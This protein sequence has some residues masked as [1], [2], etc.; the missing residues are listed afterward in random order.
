MLSI[1]SLS[2]ASGAANYFAK[3][4]EGHAANYYAEDQLQSKW[5][6]GAKEALGLGDGHVDEKTLERILDGRISKTQTLGRV[7][8]GVRFRD[9]GR[10][11][12]FSAP[13]SV[14][15]AATGDM[16][17]PI[18]EA[19]TKAVDTAMAYYEKKFAQRRVWD[20]AQG[21]Q[22]RQADQ[23]IVYA[24]FLDY[25]SRANDPQI[26]VHNAVANITEGPDGK[27][28]SQDFALG[29]R[30]KILLGAIFRAEL[31]KDMQK[32]G[33]QIKPAGKNGLWELAGSQDEILRTF[34]KRREAMERQAPHKISDPKAMAKLAQT[35]RPAK[36]K[37][38]KTDLLERWNKEMA[39]LGETRESFVQALKSAKTPEV[40]E[41]TAKTAIDFALDYH[42]ENDRHFDKYKFLKTA[43][44]RVYGHVDIKSMEAELETRLSKDQMRVSEGGRWLIPT[45]TL[46]TEKAILSEM[47]KG[48]LQGRVLTGKEFREITNLD[49]LTPGQQRAA[50][51]LL[52]DH[53]RFV[54]INGTAGTGKTFMLEQTL[55]HLKSKGYEL[56]G[57]APSHKALSGLKDT[58]VFD[59][60]MTVQAFEKAP[61]GHSKAVLIL[62]EAG[63]VGN[64]AMRSIKNFANSKNIARVA[65]I[66]DPNQLAPIEAGRP[67]EHLLENGLRAE[68][69]DDVI[70]QKSQR[71]IEAVKQLS[72]GEIKEAF[73]TLQKEV[74][75]TPADK[76][77]NKAIS[78]AK[79]MDDPSIL[80]ST[81]KDRK[82]INQRIK[83]EKDNKGPSL[84]LK[85]WHPVHL[86]KAEKTL[87]QSYE[88]VSH[89][90]FT[91]DVGKTFKRGETYKIEQIEF[92]KARLI[93]SR[94]G[95]TK[96]YAPAHHGSG[97]S[98][99][100]TGTVSRITLHK[101]DKIKF[102]STDKKLGISNNDFGEIENINQN[103]VQIRLEHNKTLTLAHNHKALKQ[104]DY[105][106]A[107]TVHSFQGATVKDNIA[108]MRADHNPLNTLEALYV[109]ASRH[110]E[111]L[112]I[113]TDNADQLMERVSEKL[114]IS[115][116]RIE[117]KEPSRITR[118]DPQNLERTN[119]KATTQV[120]APVNNPE[121]VRS[122]R[123]R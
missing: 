116:E 88:G 54:G 66:G 72:R 17:K 31:A 85:V 108:I 59:K 60:V 106:W 36:S 112:A 77:I 27:I 99:T 121:R 47:D 70:R 89:I 43:M 94:G 8:K 74:H 122:D 14:S 52:T 56:I 78:L 110:Q 49:I 102:K 91:R 120:K 83:T 15:L 87:V 35:T 67:F 37:T 34:S 104:I 19:V 45:Q 93:L 22:V 97:E 101:G 98:F 58:G 95:K 50:K 26:H 48:H 9:P 23:K 82:L 42:S 64:R 123:S 109:G 73:Q 96:S 113:I 103:H 40:H 76:L 69:M 44:T 30:H 7:V 33:F 100:K 25:V 90:K 2:S 21:K 53:H 38:T 57:L 51:L 10:D 84:T 28:R 119:P 55:P 46:K 3:G 86:K 29:Y 11:F 115:K 5:G 81:N 24:S 114:E 65:L 20:N 4:G 18:L 16:E 41:L 12:T 62:D 71:H 68:H 39:K 1:G 117:F 105:G 32:L 61:Y 6:G 13:K 80:V 118:V 92:D 63:M 75:E 107:N 111:N 79:T